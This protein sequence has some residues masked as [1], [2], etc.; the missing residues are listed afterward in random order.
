MGENT[1]E[2]YT[3]ADALTDA[4]VRSGI[5][6]IFFNSGT[7][8]PALIESWAKFKAQGKKTPEVIICPHEMVAMSAAQVRAHRS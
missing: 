5:E 1:S 7:D 3:A 4:L 8:Y 6:Y 2:R